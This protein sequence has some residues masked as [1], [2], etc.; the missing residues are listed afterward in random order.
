[1]PW[2]GARCCVC[3]SVCVCLVATHSPV[4]H[5]VLH[6]QARP[7]VCAHPGPRHM[8]DKCRA[9]PIPQPLWGTC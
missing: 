8:R 3:V 7:D 4:Y 1:M 9:D 6:I 5:V 2:L